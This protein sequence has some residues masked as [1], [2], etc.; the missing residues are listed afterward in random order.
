[1]KAWEKINKQGHGVQ[2]CEWLEGVYYTITS[3][4][5]R[6]WWGHGYNKGEKLA[7]FVARFDDF[8]DV[9]VTK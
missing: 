1:M 9:G 3:D 2:A 8:D 5:G 4:G 7:D 6:T